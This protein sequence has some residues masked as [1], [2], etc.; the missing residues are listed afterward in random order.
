[1]WRTF[2]QNALAKCALRI[3]RGVRKTQDRAGL[4]LCAYKTINSIDESLQ[5]LFGFYR[6]IAQVLHRG[7]LPRNFLFKPGDP[8]DDPFLHALDKRV[9]SL[10]LCVGEPLFQFAFH[11]GKAKANVLRH[12]DAEFGTQSLCRLLLLHP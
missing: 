11:F 6:T 8:V 2:R 1:M 9:E 12:T 5:A 4:C 10:L 3:R 7:G